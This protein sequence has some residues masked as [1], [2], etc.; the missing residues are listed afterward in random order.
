MAYSMVTVYGMND[1]I[2]NIS[3]H[4]SQRPDYYGKP[5]SESTA[6]TIDEEVRKIIDQAYT[7]TKDL[8]LS[9]KAELEIIAKALLEK[10]IIFQSDLVTLI[11]KRPFEKE[12]TYEEF[13]KGSVSEPASETFS[14][15][16][17]PV[18]ATTKEE[19]EEKETN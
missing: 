18:D 1:K 17:T 6:Q 13:T 19:Q 11:G 7:I 14:E 5:Y 12:T 16:H 3:F 15:H 8:L 2:G 10:E 4:D 9:K